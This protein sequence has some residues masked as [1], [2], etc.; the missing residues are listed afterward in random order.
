MNQCLMVVKRRRRWTNIKPTLI[1]R[2][3]SA[4][5]VSRYVKTVSSDNVGRETETNKGEIFDINGDVTLGRSEP[6]NIHT[7]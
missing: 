4:W 6:P 7:I 1:Q 3:V 2:L 5:Y